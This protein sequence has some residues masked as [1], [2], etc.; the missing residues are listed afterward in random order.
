MKTNNTSKMKR[1]VQVKEI[2][3]EN[4]I[5]MQSGQL[6]YEKLNAPLVAGEEILLD[7]AGVQL[8]ASPFFNASIGYL[9]KD[10]PV[11]V[12]Q[13]KIEIVNI[14]EVGRQLLNH[15]IGN[16][17]TFYRKAEI[18]EEQMAIIQ[19]NAEEH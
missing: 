8:F 19:K 9:L 7:F 18:Q 5:S 2:V 17:I 1:K 3:G 13:S 15:A 6:L 4:A 12:L 16:A 11:I 10:I 14:S